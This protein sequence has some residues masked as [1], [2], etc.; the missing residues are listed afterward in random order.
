MAAGDINFGAGSGS[1]NYEMAKRLAREETLAYLGHKD[2][3]SEAQQAAA[4]ARHKIPLQDAPRQPSGRI[5]TGILVTGLEDVLG[6]IQ[7]HFL[8]GVVWTEG[9]RAQI[10][11]QILVGVT[12]KTPLNTGAARANWQIGF[13]SIPEFVKYP[14]LTAPEA[15]PGS[16]RGRVNYERSRGSPDP[17]RIAGAEAFHKLAT[18]PGSYAALFPWEDNLKENLNSIFTEAAWGKAH[19]IANNLA[20]I[21]ALEDGWSRQAPQGMVRTT[22]DEVT[23]G[24]ERIANSLWAISA[25][26]PD[27]N[28]GNMINNALSAY[29]KEE[30]IP[31]IVRTARTI[32]GSGEH[33]FTGYRRL[34]YGPGGF[35]RSNRSYRGFISYGNRGAYT[36]PRSRLRTGPYSTGKKSGSVIRAGKRKGRR[37]GGQGGGRR[38]R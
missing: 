33:I 13:G 10:S 32:Q 11:A 4:K 17:E 38:S 14:P 25:D 26:R 7:E 15:Q 20:Y 9:V 16:A 21:V 35:G 37:G 24:I 12:V 2:Y 36:G 23:R 22:V 3:A 1:A 30:I 6:S 29:K 28:F 27:L 19:H 31:G 5:A 34:Q 8:N 18:A